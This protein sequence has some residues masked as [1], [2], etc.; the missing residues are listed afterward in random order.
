MKFT[1]KKRRP[2]RISRTDREIYAV[3][4]RMDL[5]KIGYDLPDSFYER[6][7][8]NEIDNQK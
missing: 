2:R 6:M 1:K 5:E 8:S 7:V 3:K 4:T